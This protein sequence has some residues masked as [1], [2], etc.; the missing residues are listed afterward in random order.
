MGEDRG[1]LS[2]KGGMLGSGASI[3]SW[4]AGARIGTGLENTGPT[5]IF[6]TS[7]A[8]VVS[9]ASEFMS[10]S[11]YLSGDILHYGVMGGVME[12]P[13]GFSQETIFSLSSGVSAAMDVWGQ[14]LLDRYGKNRDIANSDFTINYLGYSTDNGAYYYYKTE[15]GKNYQQTIIDVKA[16]ADKEKIP[17][18]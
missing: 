14:K 1:F 9:A 12:I 11:Q 16:Y 13:K 4:Q 2:Y 8:V 3:G 15:P 6:T 5:V 10:A 18:K 17:Y 7:D